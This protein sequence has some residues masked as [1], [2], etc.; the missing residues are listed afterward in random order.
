M[1]FNQWWDNL[2]RKNPDLRKC[3]AMQI[4]VSEFRR[5]VQKAYEDGG[6]GFF[7]GFDDSPEPSDNAVMKTLEGVRKKMASVLRRAA[8]GGKKD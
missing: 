4:K 1:N 7:A 5:I 3:D 2:C 8:L 6:N